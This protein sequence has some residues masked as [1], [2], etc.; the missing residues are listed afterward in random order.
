MAESWVAADVD[1]VVGR[2]PLGTGFE[3]STLWGGRCNLGI[4]LLL[5]RVSGEP[6]D[7]KKYR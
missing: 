4:E 7:D 6:L 1:M 5:P 3:K 2:E